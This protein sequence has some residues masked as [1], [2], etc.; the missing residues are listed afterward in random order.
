MR[1][2]MGALVAVFVG[3]DG[4]DTADVGEDAGDL[5]DT[6]TFDAPMSLDSAPGEDAGEA[7]GPPATD[8]SRDAGC[9]C[10][11]GIACTDDGCDAAGL[12]THTVR[13]LAC[14]S[15]SYCDATRGCATGE[16]CAT[17]ADCDRIDP[18]LTVTCSPATRTCV[19]ANLDGDRDGYIPIVCGGDDCNDGDR[20]IHPEVVDDYCD[21]IDADCSG[22]PDPLDAPGCG[23]FEQ[24]I[25]GLCAC[26]SELTLCDDLSGG[27]ECSDLTRD[28]FHCGDCTTGC[29]SIGEICVDGRCTCPV[30]ASLCGDPFSGMACVDLASD[31]TNCGR[32]GEVCGEATCT[33]GACRCPAGETLCAPGL[34]GPEC[35]ALSMDFRH[36]GS[37]G[38]ACLDSAECDGT[39]AFAPGSFLRAYG[40]RSSSRSRWAAAAD[41]SALVVVVPTGASFRELPGGTSLFTPSTRAEVLQ[42][43]AAGGFVRRYTGTGSPQ[44]T[45]DVEGDIGVV[46]VGSSSS[47]FTFAGLTIPGTASRSTYAVVALDLVSGSARLLRSYTLST[48][49]ASFTD[50]LVHPDGSVHLGG[51]SPGTIDLGSGPLAVGDRR[52]AFLATLSAAGTVASATRL[53]GDITRLDSDG[54]GGVVASVSMLSSLPPDASFSLGGDSLPVA[55]NGYAVHYASAGAHL[56]S[57][58]IEGP[59]VTYADAAG[60]ISVDD[61]AVRDYRFS[62]TGAVVTVSAPDSYTGLSPRAVVRTATGV[63]VV[64]QSLGGYTFGTRSVTPAEHSWYQSEFVAS[65]DGSSLAPSFFAHFNGS[66]GAAGGDV[67]ELR[68]LDDGELWL[69]GDFYHVASIGDLVVSAPST[70][71]I[72]QGRVAPR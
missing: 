67:H 14:E 49:S 39:C 10:D 56:H 71:G 72:W 22:G 57:F 9:A 29:W 52:F 24:C 31:P 4:P 20:G 32:C 42:F 62:G 65:F 36:C 69:G 1:W 15:G 38:N 37:C 7:D 63:M 27:A 45:L 19:Y 12:C 41:G 17:T 43:D 51:R 66:G 50:V 8:A 40:T 18:C 55:I 46:V 28:P 13:H 61:F 34:L 25:D 21:D 11:D 33:S 58:V 26:P 35:A 64:G 48:G 23:T 47:S 60:L 53:P 3:C 2:I 16:V 30:G 6:P 59:S 70:R 5:L 68:A 54:S 44:L